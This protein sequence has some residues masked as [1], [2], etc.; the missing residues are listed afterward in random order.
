M[1]L[2]QQ[3]PPHPGTVAPT[4]QKFRLRIGWLPSLTAAGSSRAP[5]ERSSMIRWGPQWRGRLGSETLRSD[6]FGSNARLSR[7]VRLKLKER[8]LWGAEGMPSR[9]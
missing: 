5:A 9:H 6:G 8:A 1:L 7:G 4:L 3:G 2:F